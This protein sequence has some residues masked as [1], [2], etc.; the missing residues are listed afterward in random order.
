MNKGKVLVGAVLAIALAAGLYL[1]NRKW[2]SPLNKQP[3]KAAGSHLAAPDFSLTD[4]TGGKLNLADYKGKVVMVDFWATWCG[5][6]R[7]EI[8]EFVDLQNRYRSQGFSVIGISVDDSAD[9]VRDFYH[10]FKMN[11]PVALGD[12]KLQ[13]L[14][15]VNFGLPTTLL[16]GR[17][18]RIYAKHV[19]ATD[20]SVFEGEI[21]ELLAASAHGEAADFQ[22][23]GRVSG[24]DKIEL[25]DP[26]EVNSEVPGV[27][28]AK[29]SAAE[30]ERF[31]KLIE[32]QKCDCGCGFNVL[33][34]RQKDRACGVSRQ[35]ARDQLDKFLKSRT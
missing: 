10:Q 12:N 17:D 15:G 5:P 7:I 29:L 33:E 24:V 1:V 31:K 8:P 3:V 2:I 27:N 9:P 32:K 25:G 34:C 21:K 14:Y 26:A 18:G 28:L 20:I 11:Y 13:E 30:K 4:L 6:C 35:L 23:T 22:Q 19:G 16:I